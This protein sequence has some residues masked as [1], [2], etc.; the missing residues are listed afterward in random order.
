MRRIALSDETVV[1]TRGLGAA[2]PRTTRRSKK[3]LQTCRIINRDTFSCVVGLP[4]SLV[5][6]ALIRA[7]ESSGDARPVFDAVCR[8]MR[9]ARG[10]WR[11]GNVDRAERFVALADQ[12]ESSFFDFGPPPISDGAGIEAIRDGNELLREGRT[13]CN[14]IFTYAEFIGTTYYA[15]RVLYPQRATCLLKCIDGCWTVAALE[16]HANGPVD[17]LTTDSVQAWLRVNGGGR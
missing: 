6:P 12:H 2:W 17:T 5:T 1:W 10:E 13:M 3:A 7:C 16:S 9:F 4:P 8:L 14:C 11:W 15:Y